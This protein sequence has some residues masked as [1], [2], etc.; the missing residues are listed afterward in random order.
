[1]SVPAW[2]QALIERKKKAEMEQERKAREEEE[3]LASVPPWKRALLLRQKEKEQKEQKAVDTRK[4]STVERTDSFA[5]RQ[6]QVKAGEERKEPSWTRKSSPNTS[7][8]TP[9][10]TYAS[11]SAS[12]WKATKPDGRRVAINTDGNRSVSRNTGADSTANSATD[13]RSR[14]SGSHGDGLASKTVLRTAAARTSPP[15]VRRMED[16]GR[17]LHGHAPPPKKPDAHKTTEAVVESKRRSFEDDDRKSADMPAWKKALIMRRRAQS[18]ASSSKEPDTAVSARTQ[19]TAS[20]PDAPQ[21]ASDS[22]GVR[23]LSD[24]R[25]AYNKNQPSAQQTPSIGEATEESRKEEAR[26]QHLASMGTAGEPSPA[27]VQPASSLD[28][29]AAHRPKSFST[30]SSGR[31]PAAAITRVNSPKTEQSR[32]LPTAAKLASADKPSHSRQPPAKP[33]RS[34]TARRQAS[35]ASRAP[36]GHTGDSASKAA[37]KP[38][39]TTSSG[40]SF[41]VAP[42]KPES[43]VSA[44]RSLFERSPTPP[45]LPSSTKTREHSS[46]PKL[47]TSIHASKL[48]PSPRPPQEERVERHPPAE[49]ESRKTPARPTQG[50]PMQPL[51]TAFSSSAKKPPLQDLQKPPPPKQASKVPDRAAPKSPPRGVAEPARTRT[52]PE[53]IRGEEADPRSNRLLTLEGVTLRAPVFREVDEWADVP[54]DDAKFKQ[55]PPWKQA[56]IKRRRRDIARRTGT[57]VEKENEKDALPGPS[58]NGYI[59]TAWSPRNSLV[60]LKPPAAEPGRRQVPQKT[61]QRLHTVTVSL[62]T[63]PSAERRP[64]PPASR[65][66]TG[67]NVKALMSRFTS[68]SG[69]ASQP[70]QATSLTSPS[71]G[72]GGWTQRQQTAVSR[73]PPHRLMETGDEAISSGD[74]DAEVEEVTLTNIDDISSDE[75]SDSSIS[76]GRAFTYNL[77]NAPVRSSPRIRR[78]GSYTSILVEPPR[79]LRKV[80]IP[81]SLPPPALFSIHTHTCIYV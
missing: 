17:K 33:P 54:E 10:S 51:A 73:P 70:A 61:E 9:T 3:Q 4:S 21:P 28:S 20:T 53:I 12:S 22:H 76:K 40:K 81:L 27:P 71:H 48:Q 38:P 60:D 1:M 41:R 8:A 75:D 67:G 7:A 15:G 26:A 49:Q 68:S 72:S 78:G 44:V 11:A 39:A 69:T 58:S 56:L 43:K 52:R 74:S 32:A 80:C 36:A 45:L 25:V 57:A 30:S 79:Q 23:F 13:V 55:L 63:K 65:N 62:K 47:G 18:E 24:G 5:R 37:P 46:R 59:K 19:Q 2:K 34:Q 29:A 35:T 31:E 16:T 64:A 42:P 14:V 66:A 50:E 77:Q 6:A